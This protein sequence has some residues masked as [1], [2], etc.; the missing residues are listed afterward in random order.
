MVGALKPTNRPQFVP[1]SHAALKLF[2]AQKQ[3][4]N[5]DIV[6]TLDGKHEFQNCGHAKTDLDARVARRLRALAR[7][8]GQDASKV[9]SLPGWTLHDIRRTARS[10]MSRGDIRP[11]IAERVLGHVIPGVAGT[12]DRHDYLEKKQHAL[13]TLAIQLERILSPPPANVVPL[14]SRSAAE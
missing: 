1:L 9:E 7:A 11:D 2:K 6:F 5:S 12:Y 14:S 4:D 8:R 13:E 10:L 3:I